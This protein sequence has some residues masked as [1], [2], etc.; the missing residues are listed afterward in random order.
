M[1]S[2]CLSGG[3][4]PKTH[5]FRLFVFSAFAQHET[6]MRST[7]LS[8]VPVVRA[9]VFCNKC[10]KFSRSRHSRCRFVRFCCLEMTIDQK[11]NGSSFQFL[12]FVQIEHRY[13][14][15]CVYSPVRVCARS[16]ACHEPVVVRLNFVSAK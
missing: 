11:K 3:R 16:A 5:P 15:F 2:A 6:F 14:P 12:Q 9:T 8:W 4:H 1:R 10:P 13:S 7:P